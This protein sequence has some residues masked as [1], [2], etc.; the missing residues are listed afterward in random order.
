LSITEAQRTQIQEFLENARTQRRALRG[1]TSLTPGQR[2][3]RSIAIQEQ[4]RDQIQSILTAEQ[5]LKAEELRNQAET[6]MAE[7]QERTQQ[8]M[9]AQLV[10]RLDLTESQQAT[11]R[12]YLDDQRA[13]LR[14]LRDNA[15]LTGEQQRQQARLIREQTQARITSTLTAEQQTRLNQLRE[16]ARNR[17]RGRMMHRR[18]V[19]RG[20]MI[21][22]GLRQ[23][24]R[25]F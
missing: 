11:I 21:P 4:V 5:K 24:R 22:L 18:G 7:R 3:D 14:G 6:R 13:Q 1:D 17:P 25:M 23:D 2:L 9:L 20:P 8:Q 15:S 16:Q 19:P 10:R 12:T